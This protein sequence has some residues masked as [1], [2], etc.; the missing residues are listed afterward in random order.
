MEDIERVMMVADRIQK[1]LQTP[2]Q[3]CLEQEME[4][5]TGWVDYVDALIRVLVFQILIT[6]GDH[7]NDDQ[8]ID[9]VRRDLISNFNEQLEL[10]RR[11]QSGE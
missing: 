2:M 9:V 6:M 7:L 1:T 11:L 4:Q 3:Q 10:M 8:V 5:E